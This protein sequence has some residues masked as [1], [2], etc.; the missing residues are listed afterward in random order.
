LAEPI[1][2]DDVINYLSQAKDI[3]LK[4]NKIVD[5]GSE[6]LKYGEMMLGCAEV[7]GLKRKIIKV[8]FLTPKLSSYWL[9]LFTPVPYSVS[10]SL[11]EG[12]KSEVTK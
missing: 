5:I 6:K 11:I 8:P 2:V 4:E 3:E 12:L 9:T 10:S 7:M 1:G